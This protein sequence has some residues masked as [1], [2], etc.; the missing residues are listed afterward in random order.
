MTF[1]KEAESITIVCRTA[2]S[3]FGTLPVGRLPCG[4]RACPSRTLYGRILFL[5]HCR[6]FAACAHLT[7]TAQT[8]DCSPEKT[9]EQHQFEHI[10]PWLPAQASLPRK[11][12]NFYLSWNHLKYHSLTSRHSSSKYMV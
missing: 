3:S 4:H 9:R 8:Y 7:A 1:H 6:A 10:S 5:T 2:A 12:S 11:K